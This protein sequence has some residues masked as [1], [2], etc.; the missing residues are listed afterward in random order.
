MTQLLSLRVLALIA[1]GTTVLACGDDPTAPR[2][3]VT[4]EVT[5]ETSETT[6]VEDEV[7]LPDELVI[8]AVAPNEGLTSGLLE[9]QITGNKLGDVVQVLFG[10]TP[11]LDPFAINDRLVV[12]L[13]P[14]RPR[15]IVDV[16]VVTAGGERATLPLAFVYADPVMLTTIEPATGHWF[17]GER[18]TLRGS[19]FTEDSVV[20][21]G[22]RPALQVTHIDDTTLSAVSPEGTPGL[23]DVHVSTSEGVGRLPAGYT[24]TGE[25]L[26][27]A[28]ATLTAVDPDHGPVA[29]GN[30]ITLTGSGFKAGAAVRIGALAATNVTVESAT[31]IV[32]RAPAGSPGPASVR[33]IQ[34][35]TMAALEDGY[36]FDGPPAVWAVDPPQGAIAG[37][38]R[39]I[40]RGHGFPGGDDVD[41]HFAGN[42]A[43]DVRVLDD[44]T[45][46]CLTPPGVVGLA[47]VTVTGSSMVATHDKGFSYFDPG[48]TPGTWGPPITGTLNV[49]VQDASAG[50]R[51]AG[52]TVVVG[53][54]TQLRGVT[55]ANGQITFSRA[56]L[57]GRQTVTASISGYQIFQLAGFDAENVT[58]PLERVPQCADLADIPCDQV[59]EPP[60]I[61]FLTIKVV[62]SEKGPSIPFGECRDWPDA[63]NGM[64]QACVVDD[65]CEGIILGDDGEL[66]E[67]PEGTVKA[68]CRELGSE[69][70][71]CSFGC[72][73][74][75]DC[76]DGFVCLDPTGLDKERRCVPPPGIPAVYCDQTETDIFAGDS[77]SYPGV[78]VPSSRVLQVGIHLGDFAAFCWSGVEVRNDFRPQFLGVTRNLGAYNDGEMVE[79]EVQLDIPLSQRVEIEVEKPANAVFGEELTIV[80]TALNLGG[81]G[82]L[83]FPTKRG[84]LSD[85]FVLDVPE[86]LTGDLYDA[87]WETFT[88]VEV[89]S[90]NGGSALHDRGIP[91]LD[92][93]IDYLFEDGAWQPFESPAMTTRALT[94]WRDADGTE[95]I[96]AVGEGGAVLKRYGTTWAYMNGVTDR[97]LLAIAAAPSAAATV[98]AI[99]VGQAGVAIHWDGLRWRSEPTNTPASLE[100]VSFGSDSVA[101]AI[102]GPHILR[103]DGTAWSFVA[104][105]SSNLHGI[106]GVSADEAIAVGDSGLIVHL[107]GAALSETNSGVGTTLRAIVNSNGTFFVAGDA[108][109]VLRSDGA[110]WTVEATDTSYDLHALW[111][112]D[113]QVWAAGGRGTILQRTDG[114][115]SDVSL[116]TTRGTLRAIA[117]ADDR[118]FAM[119]S[120]ELVL[121]PMLG[122]PENFSPGDVLA[123][124]LAWTARGGLDAHFSIIEF[125][126]SVG[127]C[128]ACGM[129]FMIPYTDWRSVLHG[130]LFQGFFP[131]FEGITNTENLGP[132]TKALTLY[133]VRS[134]ATFDFDHTASSGFYGGLWSAWSW[135]TESFRR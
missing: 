39:V 23:V 67:G 78:R 124:R 40:V 41:V 2:P 69:G 85:R 8:V 125:G 48:A 34:S 28:T 74:D 3:D 66:A 50:T 47:S 80:Q 53:P 65:D 6:E 96:V 101:F 27:A 51:L 131:D 114:A 19:G 91:R 111:A 129:M 87:T 49:T 82:V 42:P 59:T 73:A 106:V 127:P 90:L 92:R 128:S 104:Q 14:P 60:P 45:I 58:L 44:R 13:S 130:D 81:D 30:G 110:L 68:I 61:A 11:A 62:G 86:A 89:T 17:G 98:D 72:Q 10:D 26:P 55:D 100:A 120:H 76:G 133:R 57:V 122:I 93:D 88:Q 113:G 105:A 97:E 79:T 84:F 99:A 54:N 107:Q 9:V 103:W 126:D 4:A 21:I 38:T 109:V 29:G 33:L 36:T 121:G 56:D 116:R 12:A 43:R 52:A 32:A 75:A 123:D 115:W 132:G 134:D 108:G 118:L 18:V 64:C 46:S 83:S 77:I 22:G 70:A 31:R 63:S 16:T 20:L 24:Y 112:R 71:F 7:A 1:F 94:T 15:G 102:A 117:G 95:T 37:G 119:G 135:R 25:A 35:G 5:Q